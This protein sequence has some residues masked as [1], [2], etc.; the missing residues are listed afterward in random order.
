MVLFMST[1][2]YWIHSNELIVGVLWGSCVLH[3]ITWHARS[4]ENTWV[5]VNMNP[6]DFNGADNLWLPASSS[7]C[8]CYTGSKKIQA[9]LDI[10]HHSNC[11]HKRYAN[12]VISCHFHLHEITFLE[13]HNLNTSWCCGSAP[14]PLC[15][16][17]GVLIPQLHLNTWKLLRATWLEWNT[18]SNGIRWYEWKLG[19]VRPSN[20]LSHAESHCGPVPQTEPPIDGLPCSQRSD[21]CTGHLHHPSWRAKPVMYR[22]G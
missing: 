18:R 7:H 5:D 11:L 4:I 19:K 3:R 9:M 21:L 20:W 6:F 17:K 14:V 16:P 1:N 10:G 15:L 8:F 2:Q 12:V 22:K 13:P